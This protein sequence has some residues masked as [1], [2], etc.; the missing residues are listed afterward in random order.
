MA[1]AAIVPAEAFM[2]CR[3]DKSIAFPPP[4]NERNRFDEVKN[5][6]GHTRLIM[7]RLEQSNPHTSGNSL[8]SVGLSL[9]NRTPV[10]EVD[11]IGARCAK[12]HSS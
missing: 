1:A 3:R 5:L 2:N 8:I 9:H 12:L 10:D 6:L 11:D 7:A 4:Y